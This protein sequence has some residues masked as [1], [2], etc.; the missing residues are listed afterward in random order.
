MTPEKQI[1]NM[2][3]QFWV[4]AALY[5]SECHWLAWLYHYDSSFARYSRRYANAARARAMVVYDRVLNQESH[6]SDNSNPA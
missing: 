4:I 6:R 5:A 2:A 1:D 3:V